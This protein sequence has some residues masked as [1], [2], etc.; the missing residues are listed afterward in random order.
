MEPPDVQKN[1]PGIPIEISKVCVKGLY[2][3]LCLDSDDG[4]VCLDSKIDACINLPK[5]QR[6]IHVSRSVEAIIESFSGARYSGFKKIEDALEYL[7]EMLL[8]R[9]EYALKA[10]ASLKTLYLYRYI[11]D[12]IG[13][14]D[15]IPVEIAMR[16]DIY[17]DGLKKFLICIGLE[18]MTVCPCAQQV[19]A[20]FE[21]SYPPNTP[22]HS[23]RSKLSIAIITKENIVDIDD[24]IKAAL[25]SFSAPSLNLL[26]R[27]DEYR[28]VKKA[29][30]TPRFIE[31]VAR[32]AVYRV[33]NVYGDRLSGDSKLVIKVVSFES[34]HPYNLYAY[35]SY[36]IYELR[37][38]IK[39]KK[40]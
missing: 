5:K 13:L 11:D 18:G 27:R 10:S 23:Q 7:S 24:L 31:D 12:S 40:L 3:R 15:F 21:G 29:F 25:S 4:N 22:S 39:T 6:G 16:S 38:A 17:R 26:K 1:A 8:R 34:I 30:E 28:L 32:E 20:Y 36:T 19:Y 33:Y 14:E 2:R 37:E 35:L 9:H